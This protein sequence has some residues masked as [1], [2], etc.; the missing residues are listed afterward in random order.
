MGE[1]QASARAES[2]TRLLSRRRR[3]AGDTVNARHK[4]LVD[5]TIPIWLECLKVRNARR[6]QC[7]FVRR[8]VLL[9][10]LQKYG[11]AISIISAQRSLR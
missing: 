6:H 1:N 11:G 7:G 8:Q 10:V 3:F 5:P 4:K 9:D 2:S